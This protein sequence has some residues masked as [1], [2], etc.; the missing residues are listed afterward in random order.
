M[1]LIYLECLG[2]GW[3]RALAVWSNIEGS[4]R[5]ESKDGCQADYL[6]EWGN[7]YRMPAGKPR[8][9]SRP[10]RVPPRDVRMR[11]GE[12]SLLWACGVW[13]DLRDGG[14]YVC[15]PHKN[16]AHAACGI[17]GMQRGQAG[18]ALE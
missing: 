18:R 8:R 4:T 16:S 11:F 14:A 2:S 13:P 15:T 6:K 5:T 9:T 10:V 7:P 3:L 17:H 12:D 1:S